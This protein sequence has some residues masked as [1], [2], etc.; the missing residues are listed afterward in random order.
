MS[1][2]EAV[3]QIF[4]FSPASRIRWVNEL[5]F[6][7]RSRAYNLSSYQVL[8]STVS[9]VHIRFRCFM[10]ICMCTRVHGAQHVRSV[11]HIHFHSVYID[12]NFNRWKFDRFKVILFS[13]SHCLPSFNLLSSSRA[14][15]LHNSTLR[16]RL[17]FLL[18][19]SLHLRRELLYP[20]SPPP[21][22]DCSFSSTTAAIGNENVS[23][24]FSYINF[25]YLISP[26]DALP[27]IRIHIHVYSTL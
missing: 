25:A 3:Y 10:I 8:F 18:P 1:S 4:E 27:F 22:S 9:R 17:L 12:G 24:S 7:N 5:F 20:H 11:H 23:S 2:K 6:Y 26:Y 15:F 13:P 14:L 21:I 19:S 16:Y